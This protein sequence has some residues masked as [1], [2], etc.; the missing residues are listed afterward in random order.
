MN[1][2]GVIVHKING[3]TLVSESYYSQYG[4]TFE[5]RIGK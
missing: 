3:K 5:D 1:L 4:S 2:G